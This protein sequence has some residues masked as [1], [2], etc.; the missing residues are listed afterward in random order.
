MDIH[1]QVQGYFLFSKAFML[2]MMR[3]KRGKIINV[4]SGL[5]LMAMPLFAAYPMAKARVIH[6]TKILAEAL[7]TDNIQ[8][9]G[10]DPRMRDIKMQEGLRNLGPGVLGD[11]IYAKFSGFKEKGLLKPPE[12]VVKSAL[13]LAS[14]EFNSTTGENGTET[15]Y[16]RFGYKGQ[17]RNGQT[18]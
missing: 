15:R 5:G 13:F 3:Q 16:M 8:V 14:E 17:Q 10:L 4:T 6:L 11:K 7:K 9:K 1:P 12:R 2:H 18:R